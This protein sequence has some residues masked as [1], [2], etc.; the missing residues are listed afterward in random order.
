MPHLTQECLLHLRNTIDIIEVLSSHIKMQRMGNTYKALCPFH[1]EKS[2]S[3]VVNIGEDHYH[4][5]GCGAHGDAIAFLMNH[6]GMRFTEAVEWL[7]HRFNVPLQYE[8][9]KN[10]IVRAPVQ[11]L[12]E[13]LSSTSQLFQLHLQKSP[14][15]QKALEYLRKR[16]LTP[17]FARQFGLG[18]APADEALTLDFFRK[19]R[20]AKQDLIQSGLLKEAKGRSRPFFS[21]RITIPILDVSGHVMGFSARKIDDEV[22]GGKYINTSETPLF[23]KSHVLFGLHYSR[24]RIVKEKRVILAEGQLDVLRL[25]YEGLDLAVCAQGTAMGAEHIKELLRLGIESAYIAFDGD[26]AGQKAAI[27]VGNLLQAEG[28]EVFVVPFQENEDPDSYLQNRGKE[29]L[30]QIL[31]QSTPYI[32]FLVRALKK[33]VGVDTPAKKN[34][35]VCT[36]AKM[37]GEWRHITMIHEAKKQFAFLLDAPTEAFD[38]QKG[39]STTIPKP[40][41][42]TAIKEDILEREFLRYFLYLGQNYPEKTHAISAYLHREDLL[43]KE[44]QDLYTACIEQV[45]NTGRCDIILMTSSCTTDSQ[46]DTLDQVLNRSIDYALVK[47]G[48]LEV[49]Q[50]IL[51]RNWLR[52]RQQVLQKMR[53]SQTP[54]ALTGLAKEYDNLKDQRMELNH[55]TIT[56]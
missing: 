25:I 19:K 47:K 4:C 33:F 7:A 3:F 18:F 23:K 20:F 29:Q 35:V 30:V 1:H 37:L 49:M 32:P 45:Q 21:N 39:P 8:E 12:K 2:P 56:L 38:G 28:V 52:K 40:V 26:A 42:K 43:E 48:L 14:E 22:F 24:R 53:T 41:A 11:K 10:A 46:R 15:G 54:E 27:K 51:D 55:Q 31:R 17:E 5:Y 34:K 13:A 44:Y 50:K 16:G 6:L 9:G 36:I